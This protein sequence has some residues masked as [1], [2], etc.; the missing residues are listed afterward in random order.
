MDTSPKDQDKDTSD[1]LDSLEGSSTVIEPSGGDDSG[2]GGVKTPD[3]KPDGPKKSRS[4]KQLL[5]RV[6]IYLL[7]FIFVLVVAAIVSYVAYQ[8]NQKPDKNTVVTGTQSLSQSALDDL[9]NSD[10]TVGD[11]KQ[12]LS[13][14]SN[15]VFA[16]K[17]LVRSSLEVAG[18]LQVGGSLTL[19]GIKVSGD[20]VF[21]SVHITKDLAVSGNTGL[22]GGLTVQKN[23]AV[24]GDATFNGSLAASKVTT[25]SLQLAGDLKLNHHISAGGSTP[26]RSN[27]TALGSGGTASVSGSDTAGS[28][29]INTGSSP[30]AGCF[31]TIN[32]SSRF[33]ATPH[34]TITP[35]GS[36]AANLNYYINR[37]TSRF[38]VCA[39][40]AAPSHR[41][42]GFD[43]LAFD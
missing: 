29:T 8:Y 7:M 30:N 2:D 36:A 23:L 43:Y 31:I 37:N 24:N 20:S 33:N 21:D 18:G 35:V 19:T 13:V 12:T 27:G 1:S 39:T 26:V 42:F 5:K 41:T 32:F 15:A 9:A 16:G 38:S 3:D 28:I 34:I 40:N 25:D 14:Q 10:V 11:A 4:L 22:Q 6:N 17:V